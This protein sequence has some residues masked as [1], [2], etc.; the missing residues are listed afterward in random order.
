[1]H[2]DSFIHCEKEL[3]GFNRIFQLLIIIVSEMEGFESLQVLKHWISW[4]NVSPLARLECRL[5]SS[6]RAAH[7]TALLTGKCKIKSK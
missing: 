1:M 6:E 4:R 5:V 3:L 7:K 2:K